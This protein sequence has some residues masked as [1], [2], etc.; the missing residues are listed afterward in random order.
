LLNNP[1]VVDNIFAWKLCKTVD[2][3]G[4]SI[5]YTY[6]KE[7]IDDKEH[8]ATQQYLKNIKYVNYDDNGTEKF[9][10]SLLFTYEE[11]PDAFSEGRAGFEVRTTKRCS[12]IESFTHPQDADLPEGYS[13]NVEGNSLLQKRYELRYRSELP[14]NGASLLEEIQVFA[15]DANTDETESMPALKFGY[16]E[17]NP[18]SRDFFPLKGK[19][20]PQ[21]SLAATE[22]ELAD[23]DGNGLPDFIEMNGRAV[24]YWK[25]QGNGSFALPQMMKE[26]PAFS[27]ADPEVQLM[28]A[29]GDGRIDLVVSK[30]AQNG[31]FPLNHNGKWDSKGMKRYKNAPSFS[32]A[33]PEVKL[34]DLDGDGVTDVL[35]SGGKFENF[36]QNSYANGTLKAEGW[37]KANTSLR[38]QLESFPNVSFSNPKIKLAD[39]NGDGMQ[40]IVQVENGSIFYWPNLGHGKWGKRRTMKGGNGLKFPQ[41]WDPRLVILGDVVG[42]GQADLIYVQNGEVHL[43]INQSG[44]Q[45]SERIRI[46]GTP[47]VFEPDA[48][49]LV[50]L[51]GSGVAGLLFTYNQGQGGIGNQRAYFLDFTS[52]TKPYVMNQMDNQMGAIT[53]VTYE[54]SVKSWIKDNTNNNVTSSARLPDG[55]EVEKRP[56]KTTLPFPVQVV[57]KTEV[58]DQLSKGKLATEYRYS[59]GYWDG[60]EREFRGFGRVEQRDT[61]TFQG[62]NAQNAGNFE[63][64]SSLHY[65]PPTKTVNWFHLGGINNPD[66]ADRQL[67]Y[68]ADFSK[69]YWQGDNSLLERSQA[70]KDLLKSLAPHDRRDAYRAWRGSKLRTEL[71]AADANG[72]FSSPLAQKPFT[73]TEAAF[74]IRQETFVHTSSPLS[75]TN[76]KAIFFSFSEASRTTNWERGTEPKTS[77][78]FTADYDAYGQAQ[79]QISIAVARGKDPLTGNNLSSTES[80]KHHEGGYL[81]TYAESSFIHKDESNTYICDRLSEQKGFEVINDGNLSVFALRDSILNDTATLSVIAHALNYYDGNAFSGLALGSIGDYGALVRSETLLITDEVISDAYGANVPECFKTTPDWSDSN[82]YPAAFEG[83]LQNSDER[84]GYKDR[85]TGLPDHTPGWYAEVARMKYDFQEGSI[86]NPVGLTLESKDVFE[87]RSTVEYDDYGLMTVNAKQWLN[88]TDYLETVAEYDYRILQP[89]K[90]T[91][92]NDNISVVDFSPLGLLKATAL[93]GKGTEGDYK[94]ST[95]GFY[96]KYAPSVIM[97]YDFH[98]FANQGQ[99]IWVKTTQREQHYQD[100]ETSP[101]I[102]KVEYSDGFGRLLQ[103]RSQAE[104]VIFENS[105]LDAD[106][107]A[108]NAAATGIE[109]SSEDPLNVVVS[110]HKVCNNKGKIVEQYEPY[111][112]QGFAYAAAQKSEKGE[113][114]SIYY[115]S[116]GRVVRTIKP[117]DSEERIIY[118]KPT[119]GL[120]QLKKFS[121]TPWENYSYDSNDLAP[122]TNPSS[123]VPSSHYYTPKSSLVDALGRTIQTTE[124]QAHYNADTEEYEDVVMK[125]KYDIRGNLLEVIDPYDRK[126]FEYVYDLRAPQK[127]E[128]GEQQALPPLWTEHIDSG[129]SAVLYDV[130]G[131]PIESWD[132]KNAHSLTAYDTLQRPSYGWSQ[133]N[134]S[135]TLRLTSHAIYGEEATNPKDS[136][137]L[138]QIWQ[139]YDESGKTE[140]QAF[141]F[142]ANLITKKQQLISSAELKSAL[143]NYSTYLVD[144]TSLPNILGTQEFV[145]NTEFDALNRITKITLPENVNSERKEIVP[146]YNRAGALEKVN[147]DSIE[148]VKNIA[149]NAKGQR[150]LIAFGND[151]MTRYTYSTTTFRLLRQKSEKYTYSQVGDAHIYT[152]ESGTKRQDDAFDFDLAGNIL[153]ILNRTTDCGISGSAL[154]NDALDREFEYDPLY[155]IN[156]AKGRESDTQNENDYLYSDA[157]VPGNPNA[158]HVRAYTRQYNYD[159]LGNVQQL[160]QLGTNGFSRNFNYNSVVN[161]LAEIEDG[162]NATI[163]TFSYDN[164][165]NQ[166]TAGTTRNYVWNAANQLIT[167]YN[168]VG[169]S[170]PTIFAQYDYS[171][172]NRLSK[173]VRTGT[174]ATPIYERTI[175]IDGIFEYHVLENGTTY[176]KNYVHIMDDKSRIAMVRIGDQFPDDISD[177]ITYTLE[178]QIGSSSL[179][180]NTSG[181]VIDKEEYYPFGDSSLRTFDKKRYRY[182]GKEKDTESGLYYYGARYCSAWTCRFI[183]VDQLA[184][185]YPYLTPYNYAGNKPITHKDIDGLQSTGDEKVD[186]GGGGNQQ[187]SNSQTNAP[188]QTTAQTQVNGNSQANPTNNPNVIESGQ[189]KVPEGKQVQFSQGDI[190]KQVHDLPTV[191][192]GSS[193]NIK[194][195]FYAEPM[196]LISDS[197]QTKVAGYIVRGSAEGKFGKVEG[198]LTGFSAGFENKTGTGKYNL[199]VD[200]GVK[201]AALDASAGGRL[202]TEDYNVALAAEGS[203]FKAEAN[204][205][206]GILSG[207][208][209]KT[210]AYVGAEAGAYGLVG[211]VNPSITV[212][213][214][215]IGVTY[216]GSLGSAHAGAGLGGYYDKSKGTTTVKGKL[217]FGFGAGFKLGFQIE[218]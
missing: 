86:S 172:Q 187:N 7:L 85:R 196:V 26:A 83:E 156:S 202:G 147:Y 41:Q 65:S 181:G 215:K 47:A 131:K 107:E 203:V 197:S 48:V 211:E 132:A 218:K 30:P 148:Y 182:V 106:Q 43:W 34:L 17:F 50:D 133:N 175:Y 91:D 103:T 185:D 33:D 119:Q 109:R 19:A 49:R 95:G 87:N 155:R 74:G 191:E 145:T 137:L 14:L 88:A 71:Y 166:I 154:G 121:P 113:K 60:Y 195:D 177:S 204:A 111:F 42:D 58:I 129:I 165:G 122:L 216:G 157:P 81:C 143:D 3:F 12:K 201:A 8:L 158:N 180:L 1:A 2:P 178:D 84:L 27:L 18:A 32:F 99:P 130:S 24:R 108:P 114:L 210:G 78:S 5:V 35:R 97:E 101:T 36:Y 80:G 141:D 64:V 123:N 15:Y 11:R 69:E 186:N 125:Y 89:F 57:A 67:F 112:S 37:S 56:W 72:D 189:V 63:A 164:A 82:G 190:T 140:T 212:F 138:G 209:N 44:N 135:G 171:G 170:D 61:E 39:M 198:E 193:D 163:Q 183:S 213:G 38:G 136:N 20:L 169:S 54:S 55:Q 205:T 179:R 52:G 128:N 23:L 176:E 151:V 120:E 118:G 167:Y 124:H 110:G 6:E 10:C 105:A 96:D 168:Q 98:A 206:V 51:L 92:P 102:E 77:F 192:V 22:L 217:H 45:W 160:K 188:N 207:E 59:H 117:D 127:D 62:Y 29:D 184:A 159:R 31:Y 174:S 73:V 152:P 66:P 199:A 116:L 200:A 4:N 142:K 76:A 173:I 208:D 144:W 9:L 25:N 146:T 46:K 28:D 104:D 126:V 139:Q 149:Y 194:T 53:K 75:M 94:S 162:S 90:I 115:D 150:L 16:T 13:P 70:T 40:D 161:T 100:E 21:Q 214:F 153:K 134:G 68:E 93:I 79:K